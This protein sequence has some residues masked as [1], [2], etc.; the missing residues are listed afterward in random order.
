M[1]ETK[2]H[3]YCPRSNSPKIYFNTVREFYDLF[4]LILLIIHSLFY[5]FHLVVFISSHLTNQ[6]RFGSTKIALKNSLFIWSFTV[7]LWVKFNSSINFNVHLLDRFRIRRIM[8]KTSGVRFAY[9]PVDRAISIIN[10][11]VLNHEFIKNI[12][13]TCHRA[14]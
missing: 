5:C 8:E 13:L 3:K 9:G 10:G 6:F 2:R 7:L 11:L 12:I 4:V 14:S 1:Q